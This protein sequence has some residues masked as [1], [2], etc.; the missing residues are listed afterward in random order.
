MFSL[1]LDTNG[2]Y[3]IRWPARQAEIIALGAAYVAY[4][5]SLPTIKQVL[6]PGLTLIEGSL[7]AAQAEQATAGSGET[8]RATAAETYRQTLATAKTRLNLA[9]L[10]LKAKYAV[11]QAQLEGWGLDTVAAATGV[12][13]R[14]PRT[15]REWV[16]FLSSYVA[17]ETSLD[18]ANRLT[19]PPLAEMT[20]LNTALQ[21]A[22]QARKAGKNQREAAVQ[23]RTAV[24]NRLLD[25]LQAAALIIVV[26]QFEGIVTNDLQHWGFQVVART[27]PGNGDTEPLP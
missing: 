24:A 17:Q 14:K 3:Q 11:N 22:D 10:Q 16:S 2:A 27:T 7:A 13:V 1:K 8:S 18:V 25:L 15:E 12:T 4:E 6:A 23:T 9:L 5:S 20:A 21:A 19:T 26:T